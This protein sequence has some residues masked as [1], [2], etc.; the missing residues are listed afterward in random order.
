[1]LSRFSLIAAPVLF[2]SACASPLVEYTPIKGND[3]DGLTK[4]QLAESMINFSFGK[5]AAG[6]PNDDVVISS[7]P[8]P[9]GDQKYGLSGTGFWSN[10]GVT[11]AVNASFRGDTTLLQQITVNVTDQRQQAIQAL[12]G[13]VGTVGGLLSLQATPTKVTLPTGISVTNLLNS[14]PAG[15]TSADKSRP[16]SR[17]DAITC[18]DLTLAGSADFTADISISKVPDDALPASALD[19]TFRSSN[20]YY[21]ACRNLT[22]TLKPAAHVMNRLPVSAS[23]SVADP[24]FVETLR[25]PEKGSITVAPSCGANSISQ[26]ANLPTAIDYLNTLAT[27]ARAVKQ[28]LSGESGASKPAGGAK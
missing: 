4:F 13:I 14:L 23:V 20:F 15:C 24:L 6:I 27:Q 12:G 28:A 11:T 22:I 26:D 5:T 21:A 16:A 19:H 17:N 2:C 7:V 1:M 9:Y 25:F 10:W 18:A 8:V 3:A